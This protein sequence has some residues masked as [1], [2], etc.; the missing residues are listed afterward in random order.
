MPCSYWAPRGVSHLISA[1]FV[2]N[3]EWHLGIKEM[4]EMSNNCSSSWHD[5]CWPQRSRALNEFRGGGGVGGQGKEV[6]LLYNW[7]WQGPMSGRNK[8][9]KLTIKMHPEHWEDGLSRLILT[10][11]TLS[12]RKNVKIHN[13]MGKT[14]FLICTSNCIIAFS[15]FFRSL[16]ISL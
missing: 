14:D 8:E 9:V 3:I 11:A 6:L 7:E 1:V 15:I 10:A 2:L 12:N 16:T 4:A 13:H 5:H